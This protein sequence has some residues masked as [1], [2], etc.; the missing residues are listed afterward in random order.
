MWLPGSV[1]ASDVSLT[2]RM[3]TRTATG[4][5]SRPEDPRAPSRRP[6]GSVGCK[7]LGDR[8]FGAKVPASDPP[9]H[10]PPTPRSPCCRLRKSP[11]YC[12]LVQKM[13]RV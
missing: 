2:E 5:A 6:K 4:R 11:Q 8:L 13:G 9:P 7:A 3:E 10:R 1:L 12:L